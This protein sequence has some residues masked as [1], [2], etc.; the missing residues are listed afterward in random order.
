MNITQ[1]L[2]LVGSILDDDDAKKYPLAMRVRH[3]DAEASSMFREFVDVSRDYHNIAVNLKAENAIR[4]YRSCWQFRLP[5]WVY[6]VQ[7]VFKRTGNDTAE[8]TNSPYIWAS[9]QNFAI[10]AE[11]QKAGQ[12]QRNARAWQWDGPGTLTVWGSEQ[13]D[14][15]IVFCC[16]PPAPMYKGKITTAFTT[17][18]DRLWLPTTPVYGEIRLEEGTYAN[19]Q[20]TVTETVNGL[21]TNLGLVRRC[22]YSS[23]S[24]VSTGTRLH[25]IRLDQNLNAVL[26]QGDVVE[27]LT[28]FPEPFDT[29]LALR[30]AQACIPRKAS[31][32]L[33]RTIQPQLQAERALFMEYARRQKDKTGP[34]YVRRGSQPRTRRDPDRDPYPYV[35]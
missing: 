9:P 22:V 30:V 23:P 12:K 7:R 25:M 5:T 26:A 34:F 2:A 18:R 10:D 29:Y 1:L 8:T 14:D 32:D 11:Y 13:A 19:A 16:K 4:L 33:L 27:T 35:T 15:L 31:V 28:P 17:E 24:D 20:F 3:V 21:S 6:S